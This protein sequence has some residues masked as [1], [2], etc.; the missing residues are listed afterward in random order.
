MNRSGLTVADM[1]AL[2]NKMSA[3]GGI[4]DGDTL[5]V[6]HHHHKVLYR[7]KVPKDGKE[8]E[9]VEALASPFPGQGIATDPKTGG[10]V[11]ID[12]RAWYATRS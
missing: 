3:S 5:L 8:L 9:L 7:L 6:S 4:W 1:Q 12:R 11:G 2:I 10:L